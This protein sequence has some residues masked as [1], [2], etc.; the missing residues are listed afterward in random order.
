MILR[1]EELCERGGEAGRE[2][3]ERLATHPTGNFRSSIN[4]YDEGREGAE[5]GVL[6]GT[7]GD[8]CERLQTLRDYGAEYVLINSPGGLAS[9]RRFAD[10]IMPAFRGTPAQP[11]PA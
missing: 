1:G 9:L 5:A 7:P 6:Y 11:A 8:I 10:E 2:R 4:S 3:T